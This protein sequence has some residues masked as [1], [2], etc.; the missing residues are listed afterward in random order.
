MIDTVQFLY[1]GDYSQSNGVRVRGFGQPPIFLLFG[2]VEYDLE[3][4]DEP[5]W[6]ITLHDPPEDLVDAI[7]AQAK[8]DTYLIYNAYSAWPLCGT[9]IEEWY[10]SRQVSCWFCSCGWSWGVSHPTPRSAIEALGTSCATC[11]RGRYA[12]E[13]TEET[14]RRIHLCRA[15]GCHEPGDER[16]LGG[17]STGHWCDEHFE[18]PEYPYKRDWRFDPDDAGERLDDDY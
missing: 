7:R 14:I 9:V 10:V 16:Y 5:V 15:S 4:Y 12:D 11:H 13:G 17:I 3:Q 8:D 18:G 1:D 2:G 6:T